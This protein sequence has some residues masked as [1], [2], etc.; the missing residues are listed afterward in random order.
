IQPRLAGDGDSAPLPLVGSDSQ[1][2]SP[3][4][5]IGGAAMV[6]PLLPARGAGPGSIYPPGMDV[7]HGPGAS[8]AEMALAPRGP[9]N[10]KLALAAALITLAAIT[11][12]FLV[13]RSRRPETEV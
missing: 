10:A 2:G 5:E 7:T 4:I 6:P 3:G 9:S 8:P 12:V 13:G 11:T 1:P